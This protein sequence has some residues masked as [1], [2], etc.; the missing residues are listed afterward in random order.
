MKTNST[1]YIIAFFISISL[2]SCQ[3]NTL[4]DN[5]TKD[6]TVEIS[7]SYLKYAYITDYYPNTNFKNDNDFAA[8]A[9]IA[10]TTKYVGRT[11]FKFNLSLIPQN[12]TIKN[13]QFL[14]S[15]DQI[16]FHYTGA[17]HHCD[18]GSNKS[19]FQRVTQN[20]ID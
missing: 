16:P 3:E 17:G 4:S 6:V 2:F 12:A 9:W 14:L 20:W 13:A 5:P 19:F 8:V 18:S 1:F 10:D 7:G 15:Y 11:I